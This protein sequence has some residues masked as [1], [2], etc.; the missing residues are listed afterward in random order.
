MPLA[1]LTDADL[2]D[3]TAR[4]PDATILQINEKTAE[5][6]FEDA[7]RR[8]VFIVDTFNGERT[9]AS[10]EVTDLTD[11][12]GNWTARGWSWD[13]QAQDGQEAVGF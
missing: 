9:A 1:R 12:E 8:W 4:L 7:G 3:L 6:I 10:F 13:E 11:R 2:R 5:V